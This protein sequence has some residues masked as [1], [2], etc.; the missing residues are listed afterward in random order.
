MM[1][2]DDSILRT[3]TIQNELGMHARAAT[4]FVQL[5]GKFG[6]EVFI[7]KDGHEVNG[8]SIMGVLMLVASKGSSVT[9]RARGDRAM[10]AVAALAKLIDEKFGE[11]R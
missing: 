7:A 5:A 10:D 9:I 3:I 4:K 2:S 1:A 11:D 8:K 6:C